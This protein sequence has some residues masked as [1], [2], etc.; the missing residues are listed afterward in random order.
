MTEESNGPRYTVGAVPYLNAWL[1]IHR[2]QEEDCGVTVH[3]DIPSRLTPPLLEGRLDAAL[4]PS[5]DFLLH[6]DFVLLPDIA[7]GCRGPVESV[8]LFS[9]APLPEVRSV[10]ADDASRTS[11]ALLRIVFAER[12]GHSLHIRSVTDPLAEAADADAVL[13]IGDRA[14]RGLDTPTVLDLG[15]A[16][17]ELTDLPFVFAG[18]TFRAGA[19]LGDLPAMLRDAHAYGMQ[20]LEALA[21]RAHDTLGLSLEG[22][23]RYLRDAIDYSFTDEHE[24]GL[25]RFAELCVR[26]RLLTHMPRIHIYEPILA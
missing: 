10:V 7:I 18:W 22:A 20:H 23:T 24:Q 12:F 5:F 25:V 17:S 1:L 15:A 13:L 3:V 11:V 21:Q 9:W 16:W 8:R 26:H 2:F 19:D 4:V 14:M 6:D